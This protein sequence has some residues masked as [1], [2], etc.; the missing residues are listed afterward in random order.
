[1]MTCRQVRPI[2]SFLIEKE[3]EPREA[4]EA[5]SHIDHCASCRHH[6]DDLR[7]IMGSA[8]AMPRATASGDVAALVMDRLRAMRDRLSNPGTGQLAAKWSGLCLILAACLIAMSASYRNSLSEIG[9]LPPVSGLIGT[10]S[11]AE[12]AEMIVGYA[13]PVAMRATGGNLASGIELDP[14]SDL[15]ITMSILATGLVLLL[16]LVIPAVLTAAWLARKT[17]RADPLIR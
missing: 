13:A 15:S 7:R 1:M 14:A 2:I 8:S 12:A 17:R 5:R 10:E 3:A 11:V 4:L 9:V 6:E 16:A